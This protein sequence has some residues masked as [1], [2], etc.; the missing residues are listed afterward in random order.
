MSLPVKD[1][2]GY[3]L[4]WLHATLRV[5]CGGRIAEKIKTGDISS[6]A[7]ADIQQVTQIART[8]VLEWG[9]SDR[10]GFIRYAGRDDR[11][12]FI[13]ERD[14]SEDT[15]RVID[16]EVR[17]VVD[18]AFAEAKRVL[19]ENWEKVEAVARALLV[20]ET[21]SAE[22][23]QSL[24]RGESLVKPTVSDLLAAEARRKAEDRPRAAPRPRED[25][26]PATGLL[27]RPA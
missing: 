24:M 3:G 7:A 10:L 23:V 20:H 19:E 17:R 21:L 26:G 4:K 6:G 8:M 12:T 13:S 9:M 27:P 16:E 14:F 18:G 5:A 1:R 15:A 2:R 25:E 22:E 11:E